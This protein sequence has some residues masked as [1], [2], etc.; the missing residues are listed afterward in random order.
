MQ[1][2]YRIGYSSDVN[3]DEWASVARGTRRYA[4]RMLRSESIP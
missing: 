1:K 3:D 2:E 4:V